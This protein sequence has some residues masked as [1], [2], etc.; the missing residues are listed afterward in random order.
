M[1]FLVRQMGWKYCPSKHVYSII[2][3]SEL[4]H[5]LVLRHRMPNPGSKEWGM[6]SY[7]GE[8]S[9]GPFGPISDALC[10]VRNPWVQ[11]PFLLQVRKA[12]H[13]S[14]YPVPCEGCCERT[15]QTM[16]TLIWLRVLEFLD[17][18][19]VVCIVFVF[20]VHAQAA[21]YLRLL[22]MMGI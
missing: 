21:R 15:F 17:D 6:Q 3:T 14:I 16:H 1:D 10:I 20:I 9:V 12:D 4:P 7:D 8:L 11:H 19:R 5:E 13:E 18:L 2:S 22:K